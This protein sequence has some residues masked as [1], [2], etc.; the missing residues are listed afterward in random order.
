MTFWTAVV[1]SNTFNFAILL[2]I[3]AVLYKK[4][5]ISAFLEKIKNDIVETINNAKFEQENAD[6]KLK[7]AQLSVKNLDEE[8]KSRFN[9]AEEKAAAIELQILNESESSSERIKN[10][11]IKTIES[12]EKTVT[13]SIERKTIDLSIDIAEKK[14]KAMLDANP[15]LHS[16]IVDKSIE[17]LL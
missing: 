12:E 5:N 9:E 14:I 17:E 4:A 1:Q 2:L 6:K 16:E 3:F 10:S 8:I 11:Y 13:A 7:D 15:N